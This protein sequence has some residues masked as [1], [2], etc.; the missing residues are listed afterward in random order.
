MILFYTRITVRTYTSDTPIY[1]YTY[2][3]HWYTDITMHGLLH[4]ILA[5]SS[6]T[7][8][9]CLHIMVTHACM[10]SLFLSYRSPFMLHV[11]LFYSWHMDPRSCYMYYYFMLLY[12]CYRI[13]TCYWYGY[14]CYW[15]WELLICDMWT[16]TSIDSVILFPWYCSRSIVLDILF[17]IHVI[18]FYA[19]NRALVQLSCYPYHV[20]LIVL[21]TLDT[22]HNRS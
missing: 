5:W 2:R 16:S 15:T 1:C 20:L 21:V 9:L 4:F 13:V 3:F 8:M 14:S 22:W 18:L 12:S 6:Y 11:L 10:V 7:F 17:P 19:I